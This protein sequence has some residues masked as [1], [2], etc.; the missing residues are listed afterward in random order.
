MSAFVVSQETMRVIVNGI[1]R[2]RSKDYWVPFRW[3]NMDPKQLGQ[4]L[5]NLNALA[6]NGRY[7]E[8]EEPPVFEHRY[9]FVYVPLPAL[10]KTL[11]C[12]RYQCSEDAAADHPTFKELGRCVDDLAGYIV[13]TLP[14]YEKAPWDREDAQQVSR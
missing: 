2:E 9:S 12:L 5:F 8:S 10:Y 1:N 6:V 4:E 13:S 3:R 7:Q 14:D 11:S